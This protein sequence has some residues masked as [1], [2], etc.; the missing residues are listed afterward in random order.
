MNNFF[1]PYY[2]LNI[3]GDN[4]YFKTLLGDIEG[5]VN[6]NVDIFGKDTITIAGQIEPL[7]AIMYQEFEVNNLPS[8]ELIEDELIV[9]YKLNFPISGNFVLRNSQIRS[10]RGRIKYINVWRSKC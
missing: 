3:L 9:N 7:D 6:L 5:I 2:K 1:N 8:T 4:V 10:I